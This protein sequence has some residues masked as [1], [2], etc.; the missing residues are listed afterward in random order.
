MSGQITSS[1]QQ[2]YIKIESSRGKNTTE[3]NNNLREMCGDNVVNRCT[4]S[5]WSVLVSVKIG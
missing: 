2:C 3:I 4:V 1:D 5:L